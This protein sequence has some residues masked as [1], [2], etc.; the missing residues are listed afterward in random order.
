MLRF[1]QTE[2]ID[3]AHKKGWAIGLSCFAL[4]FSI[5]FVLFFVGKLQLE[6]LGYIS[7]GKT[8]YESYAQ[9]NTIVNPYNK[10][11]LFENLKEILKYRI[12]KSIVGSLSVTNFISASQVAIVKF[13]TK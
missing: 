4:F 11:S 10:G 1:K 13:T 5:G 2:N 3:D 9:K 8:F 7:N 6:H 12:N